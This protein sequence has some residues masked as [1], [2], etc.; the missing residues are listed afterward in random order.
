MAQR[1]A[2][3]GAQIDAEVARG[4]AELRQ[5]GIASVEYLEVRDAHALAPMA[6]VDRPARIFVAA[7][8]GHTRL[9]DNW[10]VEPA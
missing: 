10:P 8:L 9:I 1:L 7:R 2:V 4:L 5:S 3:H 6:E